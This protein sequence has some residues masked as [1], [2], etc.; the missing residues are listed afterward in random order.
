M[1][2]YGIGGEFPL[3]RGYLHF[4]SIYNVGAKKVLQILKFGLYRWAKMEYTN[5]CGSP[6]VVLSAGYN[7]KW[8]GTRPWR[9]WIARQTPTLKAAGSNP[10]GRTMIS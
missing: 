1:I 6:A 2:F 3:F 10:V 7:S 4:L 9:S 8:I 5:S